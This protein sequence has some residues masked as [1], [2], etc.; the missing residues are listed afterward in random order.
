MAIVK[1]ELLVWAR[2]SIGLDVRVAAQK[3]GFPEDRISFW[4]S[5]QDAPSIA[6]LRKLSEV[7]KRPLA[8]FFLSS[9][10]QGWDVMRDFRVMHGTE[11][12]LWS[13]DLHAEFRRANEQRE[14]A[15]ELL[16]LIGEEPTSAWRVSADEDETLA[17]LARE[18]LLGSSPFPFPTSGNA[19]ERLGFWVSALEELGVLV[20]TS[21]NVPVSEMRGFSIHENPM[22]VVMVNGKD[23][24]NGRIF[25]LLHEYAHLL[26]HSGGICDQ[27]VLE[28]PT[29]ADRR[30]E[31]R[32]NA[33]AASILMPKS[34]VLSH[35]LVAA[36]PLY[37][38]EWPESEIRTLASYFGVSG[39][40]VLRR[41]VTLERAP[42]TLYEIRRE[43]LLKLYAEYEKQ[44]SDKSG[45]GGSY[46][47]THARNLGKAYVRLVM[48]AHAGR[49]IDSLTA[50]SYLNAKV[51]S[52]AGLASAARATGEV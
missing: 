32:C 48:D 22:P 21:N 31:A 43:E 14:A 49:A 45:G 37:H 38:G 20:L 4:E 7:Y 6:Q 12:A 8:V 24:V 19:Y 9:P 33:L 11:S 47:R 41:L 18:R 27:R 50:A 36:K 3:S 25:S 34:A 28:R 30:L 2:K 23:A 46:Y 16:T 5:G 42:S 51:S 15:L 13:P 17:T 29:D 39:E 26:L 44:R 40:A 35:P 52:I 1:P 10:P